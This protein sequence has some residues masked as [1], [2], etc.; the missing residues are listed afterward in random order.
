MTIDVVSK[1]KYLLL[2]VLT[3]RHKGKDAFVS[4]FGK[5]PYRRLSLESW[6]TEY[7]LRTHLIR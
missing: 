7:I 5:L 4:Y 1:V 3:G 2:Y 6:K